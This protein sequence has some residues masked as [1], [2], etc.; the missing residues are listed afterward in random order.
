MKPQLGDTISNRY[1]LVSP[2]REETGLQVWKASDH[3]LARDCQLF[4]VSNSKALQ[5]V[6]ATASMLAI[7]HDSHFTKVL[8]L[9][10]VGQVALVVTQLDEGMTLSEYLALNA[11]QPLSYTAMRSIIGEVIEALHAL[12]KDNLTHFSISTD[13]VRLTRSG[14]Q[15]ADA[16]VSIMLADTSCAQALENREQLAIR[17]IA[18][19]L[20]AMLTRRPSTLSTDFRLEALAPTTPMEFR[21]ICKRGLELAEDDGFPTV[22]M[23]TIAEL[24]A[25]LGEYQPLSSLGGMDVTLPS[26][27]S[28]CSIANVPLLQILE[29]D[30]LPLPDTLAA[31][32]SIPEMT[33]TAPEPHNDFSDGKE[34]LAKSVAAT[35]GAVKSLWSSGRELLSEEDIDGVTDTSDSPFSFPIRVSVPADGMSSDDSQ[36]EKTGRIPVIGADGQVIQPG[37]ESARALKA[38]QEAIDAA[39]A[40][41]RAAVPPSFTP[42]NPSPA[43]ANT[44]VADAKLFGKLKTK[45]V[46][47][48]V[49]V[50]VV[51]VALGFAVHGLMQPSDSVT[52]DSKGPWP[53][54]NLDEV[55]FGEGDQSD[56]NSA[57]S[58]N[59]DSSGNADSSSNAN[60]SGNADS[61]NSKDS[62]DTSA[63]APASGDS[64]A[65]K[66][67]KKT[68]DK[69]VTADK[70][71]KKVPDPKQPENTTAYEIDNRK[72][73]S[74]P[75]G[76]Q[77][78]GYY[79]H[80]SQPQK[81]YRMVIKIRS[82]GGQG[83]IRV[84]ATDSP[85][86]GKQV[87]QFEFDDSGTTEVK[88]DKSV[89][90]QDIMLWV[91]LDS[92][93]GNQL[94]IES[95]QVF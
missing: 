65:S 9:Q 12:Q 94:Y 20:Y 50:I 47:I 32:G 4:I 27:D 3:V 31:A 24:E 29:K 68:E 39:Y 41:G 57:D 63:N 28:E 15:I 72:F 22:P 23:A 8:Q 16:P 11:N 89:E 46:A 45:V 44:D 82:S 49:A 76:Q 42:K 7:S 30:A 56:A 73:L 37:E 25:L 61:S 90:T 69:V 40:A 2:L 52:T 77:G 26:M 62:S 75:D 36:L 53:E 60:S 48:I 87:A 35:S 67:L 88:F 34:A 91:P 38:E 81:A 80:L 1:V 13:T 71:S 43:S 83:Y 54:M 55:P 70:Q 86:Q 79:V 18:A 64:T 66:K 74:N 51:A 59:A 58:S 17:Q 10:H 6:N 95:I 19:L 21:V 78:Y 84:N 93:P 33:F 85:S 92:L 5:E 14:I